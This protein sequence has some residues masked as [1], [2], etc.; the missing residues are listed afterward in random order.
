ML[1]RNKLEV[2]V[3]VRTDKITPEQWETY[4]KYPYKEDEEMN[5]YEVNMA[6]M[7]FQITR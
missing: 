6:R 3:S 5:R 7:T 4:F 2:K 1:T